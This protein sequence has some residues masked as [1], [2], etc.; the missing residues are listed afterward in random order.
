MNTAAIIGFVNLLCVGILA[1]EEFAI[2]YG[3][4][5]PL[6]SLD[7]GSHILFRQALIRRLRILVPAVFML[8]LLSGIAI[9]L[10]SGFDSGFGLRLAGVLALV[11]FITVTLRGTVPINQAALT[12]NPTAPPQNWK[13]LINRWEQLDTVR[14]WAA[15]VAFALF[16][17]AL[18]LR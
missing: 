18:A 14:C 2:R 13:A 16:L 17:T 1:G 6:A 10:M 12:W 7:Q 9:T 15:V 11:T 4:R 8:S 5:A 3:V